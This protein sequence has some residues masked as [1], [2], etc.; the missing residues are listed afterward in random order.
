[1]GSER[2]IISA[3]ECVSAVQ[4]SNSSNVVDFGTNRKGVYDFLLVI[5]S[6]FGP[7]LYRFWDTATYLLINGDFSMLQC[8]IMWFL[9]DTG[10]LRAASC[11]NNFC[12]WGAC[13]WSGWWCM[14]SKRSLCS[15]SVMTRRRVCTS[16]RAP[17][18]TSVRWSSNSDH[19]RTRP[20]QT[21][22]PVIYAVQTRG[23][24][25]N[26]ISLSYRSL[27]RRVFIGGRIK[28]CTTSVRQF[29]PDCN[30]SNLDRRR[31]FK[32]GIKISHGE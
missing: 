7:I 11:I 20:R 5:N 18:C 10:K 12:E 25:S 21:A 23:F 27:C 22:L 16:Q 14:C 13:I 4:T 3:T 9:Q 1:M 19:A 30:S 26:A 15:A 2:R 32:F 6:N 8:S 17:W 31:K 28:F 29:R 24:C